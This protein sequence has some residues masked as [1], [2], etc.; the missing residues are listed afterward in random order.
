MS[1]LFRCTKKSCRAYYA[2]S[3]KK[4]PKCG[5]KE[6][7]YYI[8]Y[9]V[10]GGKW[11]FKFAGVSLSSAKETEARITLAKGKEKESQAKRYVL[12][13]FVREVFIP[14]FVA[15]NKQSLAKQNEQ[16][17][18]RVTS[19]L[20]NRWLD[21]ITPA[22]IEQYLTSIIKR[23]RSMTTR[24]TYLALLRGMFNFAVRM[25]FL[26]SS[27]VK[28]KKIPV[29]NARMR[30]LTED[31]KTRLLEACKKS[32]SPNLY[33]YV[34]TALKTGMRKGEI[35]QLSP[36]LIKDGNITL[37]GDK[38]KSKKAKNIPIVQSL[39]QYLETLPE[40][41][42]NTDCRTAFR[43]AVK[44]AGIEDFHFH[45]LRHTF[46]SE[47]V[48]RGVSIY[49][50]SK[51]LGHSSVTMAMRYSHLSPESELR[52]INKIDETAA[53]KREIKRCPMCAENVLKEAIICRFCGHKFE[54]NKQVRD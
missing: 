6:R 15:K 49:T 16:H 50:V 51:L 22:D 1:L 31:E 24:N 2:L 32:R 17:A 7:N 18:L 37:T 14:Y 11:K 10:G 13:D 34:F 42:F 38:T 35:K 20:P 29:D 48:Q 21:E 23:G 30:W 54:K 46:A 26:S 39:G 44:R 9:S 27:P 45:D 25:G 36:E 43:N 40:F 53:E 41:L 8:S 3:H 47:L 19:Y 12:M 33:A 52:A 28:S 5:G 4:C